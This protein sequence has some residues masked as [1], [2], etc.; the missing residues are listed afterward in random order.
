[1]S[2]IKE[3]SLLLQMSNTKTKLILKN[4]S[5]RNNMESIQQPIIQQ[6]IIQQP[7]IQQPIMQL[8]QYKCTICEELFSNET[9]LDTHIKQSHRKHT[10]I[11]VCA[12]VG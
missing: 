12:G 8:Q 7:I 2:S 10:F 11:E 6:P 5:N 4:K 1:M 3:L 9:I